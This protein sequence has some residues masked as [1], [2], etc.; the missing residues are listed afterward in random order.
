M[1]D[2]V[3]TT[4]PIML[5]MPLIRP[6]IKSLPHWSAFPGRLVMNEMADENP[7]DTTENSPESAEPMPET[8]FWKAFTAASFRPVAMETTVFLM[9]FHTDETRLEMADQMDEAAFWILDQIFVKNEATFCH[10]LLHHWVSGR[11]NPKRT[12]RLPGSSL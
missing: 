3:S 2:T 9:P 7:F 8:R 1:P 5:L 4:A 10:R 6:F 12:G 11:R